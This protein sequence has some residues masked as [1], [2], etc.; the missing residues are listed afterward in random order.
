LSDLADFCTAI[1][2]MELGYLVENAP[3]QELYRRFSRQRLLLSTLGSLDALLTE[4]RHYPGV[5]SWEV[6]SNQQ[7][8]LEFSGTTE[9]SAQL[10]RSLVQTGIPLTEFHRL[11][12]DLE[13]IFLKLGHQQA[14]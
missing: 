3:L 8:C 6:L 1:G 14:S 5:Q 4:L 7:V 10:L 12:E 2:V 9:E 13:S 11:Q